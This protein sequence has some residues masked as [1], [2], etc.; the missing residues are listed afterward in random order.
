MFIKLN[1]NANLLNFNTNFKIFKCF[2][3]MKPSCSFNV[4]CELNP[5]T[6]AIGRPFFGQKSPE[7]ES[8]SNPLWIQQV[9][10]L[11]SKNTFF[12]FSLAFSG[13]DVTMRACFQILATTFTWP[14]AL[15]H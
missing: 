1:L 14:W 2:K 13:G 7:L 9:F 5:L 4:I 15:T 11:R 6:A 3:E 8:C 12:V 10:L